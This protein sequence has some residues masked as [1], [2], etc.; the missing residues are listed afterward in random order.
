MKK[1][2]FIP[3]SYYHVYNRGNNRERIFYLNDNYRYF[4]EKF[5]QRMKNHLSMIAFCLLPNHFHFLIKTNNEISAKEISNDFRCLFL[6]Y[7]MAINK[8]ENRSGS[9]FQK[10]FKRKIITTEK[11]L[12]VAIYYIHLNMVKH[13]LSLDYQ[14]YAWSSYKMITDGDSRYLNPEFCL[15]IFGGKKQFMDMHKEAFKD[16]ANLFGE[17]DEVSSTADGILS[18]GKDAISSERWHPLN[19]TTNK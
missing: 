14:N 9:L 16:R 11:Q 15:K 13:G 7:S 6:A 10:P 2:P 12:L 18:L 17:K 8:Q 5:N 3:A 1:D 4:L 19:F